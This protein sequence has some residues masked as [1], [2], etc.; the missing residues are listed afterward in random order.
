MKESITRHWSNLRIGSLATFQNLICILSTGLWISSKVNWLIGQKSLK[1]WQKSNLN[2]IPTVKQAQNSRSWLT[3]VFGCQRLQGLIKL[4]IW[5]LQKCILQQPAL[6]TKLFYLVKVKTKKQ[7]PVGSCKQQPNCNDIKNSWYWA[8]IK[9]E[10]S[11][12]PNP[13]VITN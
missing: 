8:Q 2:F 3:E 9:N 13:E 6:Q 1:D 4:H 7:K 5:K 10:T 12:F 11:I